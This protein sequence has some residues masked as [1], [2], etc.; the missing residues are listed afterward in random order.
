[1]QDENVNDISL[2]TSKYRNHVVT[3]GALLV[4]ELGRT[5]QLP[6][7]NEEIF[8]ENL[9][10]K[11]GGSAANTAVACT[12]LGLKTGFIGAT[13]EDS[14]GNFLIADLKKEGVDTSQIAIRKEAPTGK[15]IIITD[16]DE[17]RHMYAFT[18]AGNLIEINKIDPNY[19]KNT[20]FLHIADL[21]NIDPLIKAAETANQS[22][23]TKVALNPG[24]L[25]TG[26][27]YRNV[28]RLLSLTNIYISSIV[29][30]ERLYQTSNRKRLIQALLNEGITIV[31]LT[32]GK[33]GCVV[34]TSDEYHEIPAFPV[35]KVLDTT[36]AGDAFNAGFL[37]G[38]LKG[39]T[40][41]ECM[42]LGSFT[43]SKCITVIGA[44]NGLPSKQ[45][46]DHY[47][48]EIH[49]YSK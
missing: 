14:E 5:K 43:A 18:G 23:D 33:N 41:Q 9:E 27:G 2:D 11:P 8:L 44:R 26:L 47:L 38:Q 3:M 1:M 6:G 13:G 19:I 4:D 25:I 22:H 42:R 28:Q 20:K 12:R 21:I 29:E 48:E 32:M 15:C 39:L 17:N 45:E 37:Y 34:A 35:D 31:V 24:G 30:A 46:V 40:L 16:S 36:G 49:Q 10:I 7:E